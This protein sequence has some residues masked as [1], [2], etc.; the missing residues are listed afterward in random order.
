MPSTNLKRTAA[1]LGVLAGLL[2]AAAPASAQLPATTVGVTTPQPGS[3]TSTRELWVWHEAARNG[4]VTN[5]NDPDTMRINSEVG[6]VE[7]VG[8]DARGT[9]VGS[10]G[11]KP[12]KP[13]PK[14]TYDTSS[15]Y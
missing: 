15:P 14:G 13:S 7:L 2:A 11:V 3:T 9:Q 1:T 4:V 10:E 6:S 12:P 8:A 5:N